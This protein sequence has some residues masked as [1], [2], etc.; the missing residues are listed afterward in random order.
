[1]VLCILTS[2]KYN[3]LEGMQKDCI[4]EIDMIQYT[5]LKKIGN[6]FML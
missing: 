4:I 2:I 6:S 5:R 1:M 3:K